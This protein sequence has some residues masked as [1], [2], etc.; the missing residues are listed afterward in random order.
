MHHWQKFEMK[1]GNNKSKRLV[2]ATPKKCNVRVH[3]C[4]S[5]TTEQSQCTF[6]SGLS[7]LEMQ[8]NLKMEQDSAA[9]LE[10]YTIEFIMVVPI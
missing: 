7:L 10:L 4:Q 6:W 2:C 3:C 1:T 8:A 9:A 5:L